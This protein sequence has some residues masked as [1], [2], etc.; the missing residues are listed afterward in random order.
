MSQ[1]EGVIIYH[2]D[3][4]SLDDGAREERKEDKMDETET[5]SSIDFVGA[6]L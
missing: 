5:R 2:I 1:L 6:I 4:C 3:N